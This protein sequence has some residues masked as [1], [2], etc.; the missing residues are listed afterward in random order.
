MCRRQPCRHRVPGRIG[1]YPSRVRLTGHP[2]EARTC[3][4]AA[5]AIIERFIKA[6]PGF[7][8][9]L[10]HLLASGLKG[11]GATQQTDRQTAE[12]VVT[13]R[14]AIATDERTGS[15]HGET[16]YYLAGCHSRLGGI[17]GAARS[18][19]S[20]AEGVSELDRAMGVLRRAIAA[21]YHP[22]TWMKRDPDLDPLRAR[23]DFQALMADLAFPSE[24]FAQDR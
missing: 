23:A 2:A 18:G 24:P 6:L 5:L 20:A 14:R 3:Y 17:P 9:R 22:V 15:S 11:I 1:E 4:D 7:A 16:L 8:D 12:A 13:W 10:G 19:L 21:G